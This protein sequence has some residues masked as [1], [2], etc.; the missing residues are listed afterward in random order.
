MCRLENVTFAESDP[1]TNVT[2]KHL[3]GKSNADVKG[4]HFKTGQMKYL[5]KRIE[6]FFPNLVTLIAGDGYDTPIKFGFVKRASLRGLNK[7]TILSIYS[8]AI[9]KFENDTLWDLP[10]LRDFLL[11]GNGTLT[12]E[13]STFKKNTRLTEV[14]FYYVSL[15]VLPQKLFEKNNA[16]EAVYFEDCSITSIKSG[17]FDSNPNLGVASFYSNHIESLPANLFKNNKKLQIVNFADNFLHEIDVDFTKLIV[18]DSIDLS[19]NICV[20]AYF[21][22]DSFHFDETYTNLTEFQSLIR[23]NCSSSVI[24]SDGL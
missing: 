23:K 24:N 14:V 3:P 2:G 12:L 11:S 10:N 21:E 7:L 9:K 20:D 22:S 8:S 5:P 18:I 16:L 1:V 19:D 6:K 15:N 13:D 4:I 17:L